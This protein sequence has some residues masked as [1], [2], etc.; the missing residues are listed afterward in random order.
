MVAQMDALAFYQAGIQ[1]DDILIDASNVRPFFK[2]VEAY[3]KM[4]NSD[5]KSIKK[6][7]DDPSSLKSPKIKKWMTKDILKD[8]SVLSADECWGPNR[9]ITN[10]F[11]LSYL[12]FQ[13][14]CLCT[15]RHNN[16]LP[17]SCV[18]KKRVNPYG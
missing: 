13:K 8:M 14:I 7:D 5:V 11:R 17:R 4:E 15:N 9:P 2:K 16:K 1:S 6:S 12:V 18:L 10:D 3:F